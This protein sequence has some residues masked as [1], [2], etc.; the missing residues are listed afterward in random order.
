MTRGTRTG[1]LLA[2]LAVVGCEQAPWATPKS[3]TSSPT[4][5]PSTPTMISVGKPEVASTDVVAKVNDGVISKRDVELLVQELRSVREAASQTWTPLSEEEQA[6]QY[7][8]HDAV[9]D[10]ITLELRDQDALA[11]GLDRDAKLQQRFAYVARTMFAQ[12]WLAWQFNRVTITPEEIDQFYQKNQW[13]FREPERVKLRQLVVASEDLAKAVLVKLLEGMDFADV[14]RQNSVRPEAAQSP[15][16]DKWVMRSGDKAMFAPSNDSIR[17]LRDPILEQAAFAIDKTQSVSSYVKGAD[18]NYHIFQLLERQPGR[19]RP[20]VE[21]SDNIRN[22]LRL[23]KLNS[24]TEELRT[25][26]H[27]ERF[28]ERLTGLAQ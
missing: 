24:L 28:P 1:L 4:A 17:D 10:L 18:G 3:Q 11:R 6:D 23:Q 16:A 19:Q 22:L 20:L 15:L 21:V 8:L 26:A 14:A 9:N 2:L 13:G 27:V 12:E 7:D 5:A 25:K